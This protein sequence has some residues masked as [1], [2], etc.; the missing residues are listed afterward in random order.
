M[1]T[2]KLQQAKKVCLESIEMLDLVKIKHLIM[3]IE[4]LVLVGQE[5]KEEEVIICD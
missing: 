4:V 2:L 5:H 1:T 3:Y